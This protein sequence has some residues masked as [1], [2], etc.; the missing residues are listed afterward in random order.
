MVKRYRLKQLLAHAANKEDIDCQSQ[1]IEET[2]PC[3]PPARNPVN[4]VHQTRRQDPKDKLKPKP[5][6]D[7]KKSNSCQRAPIILPSLW[8]NMRFL[9]EEGSFCPNVKK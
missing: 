7:D 2:L 4:R 6:H 1:H 8:E 9:L 5:T 3:A